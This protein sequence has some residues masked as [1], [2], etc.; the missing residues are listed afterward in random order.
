MN[1]KARLRK[2][3][4]SGENQFNQGDPVPDNVPQP[5][6]ADEEACALYKQLKDII[7]ELGEADLGRMTEAELNERT[8]QTEDKLLAVVA[9]YK[10]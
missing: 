4:W 9:Q 6:P 10:N 5:T 7:D 3:V 2:R 8:Q 1:L